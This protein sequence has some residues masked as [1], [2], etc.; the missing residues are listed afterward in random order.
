MRWW[1]QI[2]IDATGNHDIGSSPSASG[3]VLHNRDNKEAYPDGCNAIPGVRSFVTGV[4]LLAKIDF[5][6][7]VN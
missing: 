3:L 1:R 5:W 7:I 6:H 2:A 4:V